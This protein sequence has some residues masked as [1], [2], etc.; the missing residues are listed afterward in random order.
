M[1]NIILVG[2]MGTGKSVVGKKLAAKLKRN[3][4]ELDDMI[5]RREKI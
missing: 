4:I 3:F 1:D 5:K 2:F